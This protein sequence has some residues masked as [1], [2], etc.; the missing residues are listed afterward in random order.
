MRI[1]LDNCCYNRQH[2]ESVSNEILKDKS[3]FIKIKKEIILKNIE[4]VTSFMLHYENNQNKNINNRNNNDFLI[5]NYR[6]IYIGVD[7]IEK[8]KILVDE[9]I[10]SGVKQKEAYHIASAILS[11]CDYFITVDKKLLKYETDKIKIINLVDF[12][13][14]LEAD[15]ND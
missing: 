4:L 12:I 5:R 13:K 3:A 14:I 2:D 1:Y 6:T 10:L 9:I 8:L 7:S 15:N 11:D